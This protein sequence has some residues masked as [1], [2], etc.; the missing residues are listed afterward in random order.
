M[1]IPLIQIEKPGERSFSAPRRTTYH[2]LTKP[3]GPICNLDCTYCYYL[4]KE[5][6]YGPKERYRMADDLLEE[7]IKQYI[8]SQSQPQIEMAWQGGEPTLMGLN[9]FKRIVEIQQKY[10]GGKTIVNALQTNGTLLD[11]EWG[12]FL[13]ANQ[14]L[15]GISIDGPAHLHDRY[16]V[17]K[18]Q[19]PTFDAVM[20]GLDI[21][22]KHKVEFNTLTVVSK[23]NQD[24]ALEVYEFLKSIGSHYFQFI[25]L[26]ERAPDTAA[27]ALGLDRAL[28]PEREMTGSDRVTQ[29]SVGAVEFG[30]FLTTIFERWV[31]EDVGNIFVQIFDIALSQMV[32]GRAGLCIFEETCGA[33]LAIEHNG[34]LYSCDHYVYPKYKLG[35]IKETPLDDLVNSPQQFRFGNDKRDTLP[36]Y[37]R[38]CEVRFACNGDCPKHRFTVTPDGEEGLSYLCPS[39]KKF[40]THTLPYM[41]AMAELLRARR[42]PADIMQMVKLHDRAIADELARKK[43][44]LHWKTAGRNA[45]CPC[46]SGRKY[47]KCCLGKII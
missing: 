4:E 34:D 8:E 5:K 47:K 36:K 42:A 6:L 28:P 37:C 33:S 39:Y 46:G 22:K 14:F 13:A 26:V 40:F 23:N 2:V 25:P 1:A 24:H 3:I 44:D 27:R 7:Y 18:Q 38:E 16:R 41:R 15:V 10:A 17:D 21:L 43:I 9:F 31:R 11:D 30:T 20:R 19:R 29:W 32:Q 45:P 12:E 35:N